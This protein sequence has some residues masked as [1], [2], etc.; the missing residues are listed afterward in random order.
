MASPKPRGGAP[1]PESIGLPAAGA[2]QEPEKIDRPSKAVSPP[3]SETPRFEQALEDSP[4]G[5]ELGLNGIY[6]LRKS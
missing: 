5:S 4:Q 2:A 6:E 3:N 1:P